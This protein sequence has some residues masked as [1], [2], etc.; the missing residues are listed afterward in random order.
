MKRFLDFLKG[1]TSIVLFSAMILV[2]IY[3]RMDK[4][5]TPIEVGMLIIIV[6][7]WSMLIS[8]KTSIEEKIFQDYKRVIANFK[9]LAGLD[10]RTMRWLVLK[11]KWEKFNHK[12]LRLNI[13]EQAI[14]KAFLYD[15][16]KEY[17]MNDIIEILNEKLKLNIVIGDDSKK[18]SRENYTELKNVLNKYCDLNILKVECRKGIDY[19]SIANTEFSEYVR[20][21]YGTLEIMN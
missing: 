2:L 3:L 17:T 9:E 11:E 7:F 20:Q 6:F 21:F 13:S 15:Q 5:H 1:P 16:N 18:D 12:N 19:Y 10:P 14:F 8:P 4:F